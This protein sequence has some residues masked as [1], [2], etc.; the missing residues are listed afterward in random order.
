MNKFMLANHEAKKLY[1]FAFIASVLLSLIIS[2]GSMLNPDG[3]CYL[4]SAEKLKTSSLKEVMH[5][6]PQAQWPFYSTLIYLVEKFTPLSYFTSA[7]LLDSLFTLLS[8]FAFLFIV[9]EMG[10]N[11]RVLWLACLVFL[12]NHQFNI[13]RVSIIR[14]HGFWAFYLCSILFMVRYFKQFKFYDALLWSL[15]IFVAAL[16]RIEGVIF[17]ITLPLLALLNVNSSFRERLQ[18]FFTLNFLFLF[19]MGLFA[20]WQ[21]QHSQ[22]MVL[23]RVNEIINQLENGITLL[24]DQY[25]FAK[26]A[27]IQYV[28]PQEAVADA[29]VLIMVML[30]GW[31]F[32]NVALT[33]SFVYILLILYACKVRCLQLSS[34]TFLVL[35]G[36]FC[37]NIL[38][39]FVF[40]AERLFISKR[41]LVALTLVLLLAVPFVLD[42]LM[43]KW[44]KRIKRIFLSL[45]I[46]MIFISA[47]G[48]IIH[49]GP[50]KIYI[51]S[52]GNW[53]AHNV[54]ENAKIYV[55]DFQ[56]MYYSKHLGI[57]IF[58]DFNEAA[59]I[60]N[61]KNQHWKNYDY[62][63]ILFNHHQ[64]KN[65]EINKVLKNANDI[66]L[67]KIFSNK[68]GD[69]IAIY[70]VV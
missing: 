1:S 48:S 54:P 33:L 28:L 25:R 62:L 45:I 21:L 8:V 40:L 51:R 57:D 18:S 22:H 2:Y 69:K 59:N 58:K 36:Y 56:L 12:A 63:A 10:G 50:S 66:R 44:T 41:Y 26:N 68:R 38:I 37:L 39:T 23:G 9:K 19:L 42:N 53:L 49:L 52:A 27:L 30:I 3:I 70:K 7:H 13:L 32:Y 46:A 61:I 14:D 35:T 4:L 16:F 64:Q 24:I 67:V 6:C 65:I 43:Q 31:Y 60:N 29:G 55:N 17:F 34:S 11:K 15:S 20:I 47:L 5:F